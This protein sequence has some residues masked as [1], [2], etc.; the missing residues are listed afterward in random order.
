MRRR[1]IGDYLGL[2]LRTI[3][4]AVSTRH[5]KVFWSSRGQILCSPK[6][7]FPARAPPIPQ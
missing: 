3:H 2:T 7:E 6:P 5:P 4:R 1:D